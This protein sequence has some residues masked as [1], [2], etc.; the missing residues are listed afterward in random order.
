MKKIVKNNLLGLMLLS[1]VFGV[2]SSNLF[3]EGEETYEAPQEE[4]IMPLDPAPTPEEP[5]V[6]PEEGQIS[7]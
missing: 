2:A 6:A 5:V 3:A 7:E 1:F 4:V